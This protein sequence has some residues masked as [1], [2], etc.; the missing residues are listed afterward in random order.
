[1]EET[2]PK[3]RSLDTTQTIYSIGTRGRM[4]SGVGEEEP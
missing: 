1:M 2:T 3:C 4:E